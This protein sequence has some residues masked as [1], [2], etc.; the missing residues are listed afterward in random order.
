[1]FQGYSEKLFPTSDAGR[2]SSGNLPKMGWRGAIASS[3]IALYFSIC[4][5]L[6]F[7]RKTSA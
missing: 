4:L 6:R 5:D 3:C 7:L 2:R 1:M